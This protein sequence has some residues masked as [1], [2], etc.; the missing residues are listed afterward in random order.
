MSVYFLDVSI[1]GCSHRCWLIQI[2]V[3]HLQKFLKLIWHCERCVILVIIF[4][5]SVLVALNLKL[6]LIPVLI[7]N[8]ACYQSHRNVTCLSFTHHFIQ[9][10]CDLT[11]VSTFIWTWQILF[12]RMYSFFPYL[13]KVRIRNDYPILRIDNLVF[14]LMITTGFIICNF[15]QSVADRLSC[16]L[17]RLEIRLN[18]QLCWFPNHDRHLRRVL[19]ATQHRQ[20]L[21]ST[22]DG[23]LICKHVGDSFGRCWL[24]SVAV[25][26]NEF[27]SSTDFIDW[28]RSSTRQKVMS[29][30]REHF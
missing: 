11:P 18:F 17:K 27:K 14:D 13:R 28:R 22:A 29:Y 5:T 21:N 3:R 1:Y 25:L 24:L 9:L 19:G 7:N 8:F 15:L 23:L 26:W 10:I 12:E 4:S 2:F 6:V 16:L 30:N 20:L